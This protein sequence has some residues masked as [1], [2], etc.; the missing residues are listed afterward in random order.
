[1][2]QSRAAADATAR[3]AHDRAEAHLAQVIEAATRDVLAMTAADLEPA[4]TAAGSGA[5]DS[6]VLH[7]IAHRWAQAVES[8]ILPA[9]EAVFRTAAQRL[10]MS[11]EPIPGTWE[12]PDHVAESYLRHAANRMR[13]VSDLM[14]GMARNAMTQG[15]RLGEAPGELAARVRRAL[16]WDAPLQS[17]QDKVDV[18]ILERD[19]AQAE[20]SKYV[21][22]RIR[23]LDESHAAE[24][25]R[26]R[27]T[28]AAKR[29]ELV[30]A[31][32]NLES[33]SRPYQERSIMVARTEVTK[34]YNA[35]QVAGAQV[36][37]AATGEA[38]VKCWLATDDSRTREA[39]A[40]ADGQCV[41]VGEAFLVGEDEMMHPGDPS[42][43]AENVIGC[44]C[45]LTISRAND[46]A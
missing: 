19:R 27:G 10:V 15:L 9:L 43:S 34:S 41:P 6:S 31:R 44:R 13:G 21:G 18:A 37:Q 4:L 25:T 16:S 45:S 28:L 29:S 11:G 24:V 30:T 7:R 17:A 42:A 12:V 38:L 26:A 33:A 46:G 39:H 1:M 3:A 22:Q 40:E 32:R 36:R 5:F 8:D 14:F 23:D 2:T 20:A 35:G